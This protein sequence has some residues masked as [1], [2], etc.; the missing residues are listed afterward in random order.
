MILR[1]F[2]VFMWSGWSRAPQ[3]HQYSY[4]N[5]NLFSLG[6]PGTLQ[7]AQKVIFT[8]I[9][10]KLPK[11]SIISLNL[12]NFTK[13]SGILLISRF[14]WSHGSEP[15]IWPR[16]NKGFVKGRGFVENVAFLIFSVI[17]LN[18]VIF[19]KNPWNP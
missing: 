11:F 10:L 18:L 13:F 15:S 14:W 5:I 19:C 6:P 1:Y 12:W 3:K 7:V 8:R 9:L 2:S 4:R 17:S 16:K